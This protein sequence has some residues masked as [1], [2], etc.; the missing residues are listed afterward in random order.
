M[1]RLFA[2]A[3][4]LVLGTTA[5][6][7]R[8][9]RSNCHIQF[10]P[11]QRISVQLNTVETLSTGHSSHCSIPNMSGLV[12]PRRSTRV[13]TYN[14]GLG[15]SKKISM[16]YG[17]PGSGLLGSSECLRLRPLRRRNVTRLPPKPH[18]NT[19]CDFTRKMAGCPI[20]TSRL[21]ICRQDIASKCK[22]GMLLA[23][24]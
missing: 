5:A 11:H 6:L 24:M 12:R 17:L 7:C 18:V 14:N 2:G 21:F 19:G 20:F 22:T 8:Y 16:F 15:H 9:S 1:R 10:Q 13:Y 3:R 23:G 4:S